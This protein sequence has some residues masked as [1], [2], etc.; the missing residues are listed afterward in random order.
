[1]K[2]ILIKRP[3]GVEQLYMGEAE[4]PDP[5]DKEILVKV[6]ATSVNRMDIIQREG[7]YPVPK[8][9]SPILGVD[10]AGVVDK[11]GP[12]SSKWKPGDRVMGLL[13][14]GAYAEYVKIHEDLVMPLPENF[15]FEEGASIPEVFMTA[16]QTLFFLGETKPG[17]DVLLH[18][19]ASGVGTAAIQLIKEVGARS[20]VTAGSREKIEFCKKLGAYEGFNYKDG[21]FVSGVLEMTGGKGVDLILDFVGASFWEQNLQSLRR[22]GRLIIIGY[23]GGSRVA[24]MELTPILRNWIH[25][26]GTTLRA[27]DQGYQIRLVKE[28]SSFALDRLRDGRLRPVIDRVYSWERVQEAHRYME[29]NRNIGKIVMNGM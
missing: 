27:R 2:A 19:G 1:M 9:A 21:P 22:E 14:G 20:L 26:I 10:M 7:R 25:V 5:A 12:G 29:E 23:L 13:S 24:N 18:A 8:G 17:C 11:Q 4:M 3:G 28:L 16:Y 6:M 15:S